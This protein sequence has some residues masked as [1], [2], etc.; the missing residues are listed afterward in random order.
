MSQEPGTVHRKTYRTES[1]ISRTSVQIEPATLEHIRD[2]I[3][4][5]GSRSLRRSHSGVGDG[6]RAHSALV[7]DVPGTPSQI[8]AP[9]LGLSLCHTTPSDISIS[10]RFL[11]PGSSS[12]MNPSRLFRGVSNGSQRDESLIT[13]I[14]ET[15]T[16]YCLT[17]KRMCLRR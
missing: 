16:T 17:P 14:A 13:N 2:T 9:G 8:Y 7:K 1:H 6:R 12:E 15:K 10:T 5:G 3:L 11:C 4:H